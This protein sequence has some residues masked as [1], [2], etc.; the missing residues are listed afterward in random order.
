MKG[1]FVSGYAPENIEQ[2]E[3][4]DL[5]M[6]VLFK[7]VSPKELLRAIRRVLDMD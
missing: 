6:E 1:I 2:R 4:S 5:R 7:P 3:L